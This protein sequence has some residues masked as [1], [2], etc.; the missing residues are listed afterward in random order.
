[1]T[2]PQEMPYVLI[3]VVVNRVVRHY[4]GSVAEVRRPAPQN[5]IQPVPRLPPGPQVA[6]YQKLP[7]LFLDACHRFLRRACPQIPMAILLVTMWPE[8]LSRP[9]EFHRR[10]LAE[11]SVRLSPHS[12]PIKQTRR[13]Y[14]F[15]NGRR[16]PTAP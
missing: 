16:D 15:A 7:H 8:R 4:P 11:P 9:M 14:R 3:N 10:P 2:P 13:P 12:A 5:L 6:G 1:M